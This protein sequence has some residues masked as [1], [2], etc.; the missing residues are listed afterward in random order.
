MNNDKVKYINLEET[1]PVVKGILLDDDFKVLLKTLV[2][3]R[4]CG[5]LGFIVANEN[6]EDSLFNHYII[7]LASDEEVQDYLSSL[8]KKEKNIVLSLNATKKD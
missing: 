1:L 2:S 4:N 3:K 5:N 6:N 8:N 7:R